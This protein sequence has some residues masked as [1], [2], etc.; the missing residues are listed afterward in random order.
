MSR[1]Q[2]YIAETLEA[3]HNKKQIDFLAEA[4]SIIAKILDPGYTPPKATPKKNWTK[5]ESYN[6][7][8]KEYQSNVYQTIYNTL[9]NSDEDMSRTELANVCGLRL[10]TVCGRVAELMEAGA[11]QVVGYKISGDT[12]RKVEVLSASF[13]V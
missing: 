7:F 11:V 3:L 9:A 10:A 8:L 5:V 12:K 13:G 4:D 6:E 2:S 1:L